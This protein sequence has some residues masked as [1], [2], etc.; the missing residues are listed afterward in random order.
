M[1]NCTTF[2]IHHRYYLCFRHKFSDQSISEDKVLDNSTSEIFDNVDNAVTNQFESNVP[3]LVESR[4]Q[5]LLNYDNFDISEGFFENEGLSSFLAPMENEKINDI[6]DDFEVKDDFGDMIENLTEEFSSAD[7]DMTNHQTPYNQ[8]PENIYESINSCDEPSLVQGSIELSNIQE[9]RTAI[10]EEEFDQRMKALILEKTK[11][12]MEICD[13]MEQCD[14]ASNEAQA[15]SLAQKLSELRNQRYIL[16]L[17]I[18][19]I[20]L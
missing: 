19:I 15:Q 18:F 10:T 7:F 6:D 5:S 1:E 13:V 3:N 11:L 14:A 20:N 2:S 8:T 17:F 12:S 9:S 4:R 16:F